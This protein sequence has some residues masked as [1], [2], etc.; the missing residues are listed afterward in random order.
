MFLILETVIFLERAKTKIVRVYSE[1]LDGEM[2]NESHFVFFILGKLENFVDSKTNWQKGSPLSLYLDLS[3]NTSQ[4][5][6]K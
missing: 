1:I 6:P 4:I 2:K 3:V 5:C